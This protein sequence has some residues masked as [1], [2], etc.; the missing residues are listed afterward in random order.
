M[1]AVTNRDTGGDGET[2]LT[3]LLYHEQW[4]RCDY[5]HQ[6]LLNTCIVK[7]Q[8]AVWLLCASSLGIPAL[9]IG[10]VELCSRS[11]RL[12]FI[13]SLL[14]LSLR[15]SVLLVVSRQYH[16]EMG[17]V[18]RHQLCS[19]SCAQPIPNNPATHQGTILQKS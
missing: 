15:Y 4:L 14:L 9:D 11:P 10:D 2:T 6:H 17:C 16:A 7:V 8:H 1:I 12:V 3:Q 18:V 5:Y 13:C 19:L